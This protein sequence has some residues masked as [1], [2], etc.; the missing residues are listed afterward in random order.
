MDSILGAGAII[1]LKPLMVSVTLRTGVCF[2]EEVGKKMLGGGWM[3][4]NF[5][6]SKETRR[7]GTKHTC[8]ATSAKHKETLEHYMYKETVTKI[9]YKSSTDQ[10]F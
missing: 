1:I 9:G 6:S 3:R 8:E 2:G 4:I 5:Q 10:N 7:E